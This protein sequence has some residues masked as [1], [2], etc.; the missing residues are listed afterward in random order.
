MKIRLILASTALA[1]TTTVAAAQMKPPETGPAKFAMA[2][3]Y[4]A[5]QQNALKSQRKLLL[6]FADS[7]PERLY[8]DRA[9]PAQRSF[10]E[11]VHHIVSANAMIGTVFIKGGA[12]GT[13]ADTAVVLNS[14]AGLKKYINDTYDMLDKMITDQTDAERDTQVKFFGNFI[15]KWQV[16]DELNQH[17]M[18][19]AGQIVANFRKNG[20]APPS[21]L[22]F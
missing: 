7:M 5:V 16:W 21:F 10:A 18:W 9:T 17:S 6:S 20:M 15:P 12:P 8:R 2:K 4:R 11:Q 13:P 3:E 22:F 19:T 1:A 14:R